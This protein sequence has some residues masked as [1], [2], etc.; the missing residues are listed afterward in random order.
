ME[1]PGGGTIHAVTKSWA[2]LK[3]LSTH[4]FKWESPNWGHWMLGLLLL[5]KNLEL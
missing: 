3:R 4:T 2:R 1:E 5:G